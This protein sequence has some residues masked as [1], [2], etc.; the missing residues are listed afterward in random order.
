L[1]KYTLTYDLDGGINNPENPD[2]YAIETPTF[3][4]KEPTKV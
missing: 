2:E 1:E 4:I 3:T